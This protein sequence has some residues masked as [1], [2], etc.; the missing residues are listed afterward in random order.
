M[1]KG[2]MVFVAL[3]ILGLGG[4]FYIGS[5][6]EVIEKEVVTSEVLVEQPDKVV[7]A[8]TP[9]VETEKEDTET[10]TKSNYDK[11]VVGDISTGEG[12]M[13]ID[14]VVAILGE[15]DERMESES[16]GIEGEE[17]KSTDLVWFTADFETI[18]VNFINGKVMFKLWQD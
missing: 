2:I 1:K 10:V 14:E 9:D 16:T 7:E 11:I 6:E 17:E 12:G 3:I 4:L 8:E 15:P 5:T 18:S 13:T